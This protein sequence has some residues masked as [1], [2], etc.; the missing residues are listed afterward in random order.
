M[1]SKD[2]TI[3]TNTYPVFKKSMKDN[4]DGNYLSQ[5]LSVIKKKNYATTKEYMDEYN[6][7]LNEFVKGIYDCVCD[8][9]SFYQYVESGPNEKLKLCDIGNGYYLYILQS[10]PYTILLN[11]EKADSINVVTKIPYVS[12]YNIHVQKYVQGDKTYK[13]TN[14]YNAF[15]NY[16]LINGIYPNLE[17]N[18][19][20]Y[21]CFFDSIRE[22]DLSKR[23]GCTRRALDVN[24]PKTGD[25]YNH[26]YYVVEEDRKSDII[27]IVDYYSSPM[28]MK[29]D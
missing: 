5:P 9:G 18:D 12:N 16:T 23:Y 20:F 25:K 11:Y 22:V 3:I 8:K 27:I 15:L 21:E 13:S 24:N 4:E 7:A 2:L 17:A 10:D 19:P 6:S 14:T 1:F 29:N 26:F 28:K